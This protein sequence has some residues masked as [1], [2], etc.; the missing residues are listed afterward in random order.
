MFSY[1]RRLLRFRNDLV[2]LVLLNERPGMVRERV[3]AGSDRKPG[4][5]VSVP[6]IRLADDLSVLDPVFPVAAVLRLRPVAVLVRWRLH[7]CYCC[8]SGQFNKPF[9]LRYQNYPQT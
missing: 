4:V 2:K 9:I 6:E 1:L 8:S 7:G 3:L 5:T